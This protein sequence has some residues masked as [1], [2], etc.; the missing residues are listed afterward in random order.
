MIVG[1]VSCSTFSVPENFAT[2]VKQVTVEMIYFTLTPTLPPT[3]TSTPT[4]PP[5]ETPTQTP[6]S[7]V[8]PT[9]IPTEHGP[10]REF[11]P[12]FPAEW[13]KEWTGTVTLADGSTLKIPVIVGLAS[14]VIH[15]PYG[16]EK[17]P[18][19][20]VWMKQ[21]GADVWADAYLR[22]CYDRFT[23]IMGNKGVT[24][25]Q[26][27]ELLEKPS[28][29]EISLVILNTDGKTMRLAMIDPRQ[30]WSVLLTNQKEM[31][32][33][34]VPNYGIFW[35]VDGKGRLLSAT[36]V[37]RAYPGNFPKR[38]LFGVPVQDYHFL[39]GAMGFVL[40]FA[41]FDNTCLLADTCSDHAAD[42]TGEHAHNWE[43]MMNAIWIQQTNEQ[44]IDPIFGL[45]P[46]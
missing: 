25:E 7:T 42:P 18:I 20:G 28:G 35:G 32:E 37:V 43:Q 2:L 15:N 45:V 33:N 29:G 30:G 26:Y 41:V 12:L 40:D 22:A 16:P 31:P 21:Q 36:N 5:T 46:P 1:L 17:K 14:D 13:S 4:I 8:T 6:T 9:P 38:E 3:G 24:Y 23:N 11:S 19:L 27:L 34:A 44:K 10:S 39:Q